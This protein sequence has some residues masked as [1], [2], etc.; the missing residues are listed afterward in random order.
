MPQNKYLVTFWSQRL[1]PVQK[2]T[3]PRKFAIGVPGFTDGETR[4]K[5]VDDEITSKL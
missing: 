2:R 5:N 3:S 1:V 4:M